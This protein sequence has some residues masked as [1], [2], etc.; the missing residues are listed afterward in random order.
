V[1]NLHGLNLKGEP[2]MQHKENFPY[3]ALAIIG[4]VLEANSHKHP[5]ARW[6]KI[7]EEEHIAHAG[8]HIDNCRCIGEPYT[9][10]DLDHAFTRLAMA[11]AIRESKKGES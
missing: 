9:D 7:P 11:I 2:Q 1:Q 5:Q 8:D 3:E 10:E 6:R 4:K